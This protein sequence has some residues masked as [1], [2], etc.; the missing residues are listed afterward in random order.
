MLRRIGLSPVLL[1]LTILCAGWLALGAQIA[2]SQEAPVGKVTSFKLDNG[3]QI[4]VIEDHRV[5]V[6]THMVWYK[7]GSIDDPQGKSGLA[8][9]LEHLMFKSCN[10][11][12]E[13][14]AESFS[15]AIARLG[16]IDNATTHHDT[17]HYFQRV[18]KEGL[19]DVMALEAG[20]M[21]Q[22]IFKED[23]VL[24][25]RNVVREERRSNIES[26]PIKLL[27]EQLTG[28]LYLN[29]SYGR[30][31]IGWSYEIA[32][33]TLE[34]ARAAY[35]R[36]YVPANAI[37]VIA[38]DVTPD[39]VRTLAAETYAKIQSGRK[40]PERLRTAEPE[41][42]TSRRLTLADARVP[43]PAFFRY[44]L[45]PSF[46]SAKPM[47]AESLEVLM[48]ILGDGETSRLYRALVTQS[49]TALGV[50]ARYSGEGRDSG[51]IV[52]FAIVPDAK[53]LAATEAKLDEALEDVVKNGIREEELDRAKT[54]IE[55]R[56]IIE[57]DNQMKLATR[58]G[59][60]LAVGRTLEAVTEL[61]ERI[62]K[63]TKADVDAAA[64]SF[65]VLRR[66]V[67]GNL[68]PAENEKSVK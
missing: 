8:H 3:L 38:G 9:L 32:G 46:A 53:A 7:I 14:K 60:A 63:V 35:E 61:P 30:P 40:V 43:Q 37:V 10:L 31:P 21:A 65:L 12:R 59:Q 62:T 34:D 23:E 54:A 67:T 18:A 36:F 55:A 50:G 58:Y 19:R 15:S 51:R 20:R 45:A 13:A 27:A 39:E 57:S 17:T 68:V 1:L 56:L 33:L 52:V 29:H 4:A 22:L 47:E 44:Y 5:P 48:T 6:V 66:S 2:Q 26:E 49:K 24:T 28:T 41:P 16:A 64:H 42:I 25:E 11:A